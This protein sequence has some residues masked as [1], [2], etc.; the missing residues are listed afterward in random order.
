MICGSEGIL[1][2]GFRRCEEVTSSR[3]GLKRRLKVLLIYIR[4]Q[5]INGQS[6]KLNSP[7][8]EVFHHPR[9][10]YQ[11]FGPGVGWGGGLKK[12]GNLQKNKFG[13][14]LLVIRLA[15]LIQ[16]SMKTLTESLQR[17]H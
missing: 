7:W 11:P 12:S 6:L 14:H 2:I 16:C 1:G 15:S 4:L 10:R 9:V 8:R 13:I 5:S 3:R 17:I